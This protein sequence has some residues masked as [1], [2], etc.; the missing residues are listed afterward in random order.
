MLREFRLMVTMAT[1]QFC[2][3]MGPRVPVWEHFIPTNTQ[4]VFPI[5]ETTPTPK[6]SN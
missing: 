3:S 1:H 6:I 4:S 5:D 2:D